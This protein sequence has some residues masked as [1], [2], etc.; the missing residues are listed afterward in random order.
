M[1]NLNLKEK[2]MKSKTT[3]PALASGAEKTG[4]TKKSLNEYYNKTHD[5][6]ILKSM[7]HNLEYP[8]IINLLA[9][10]IARR[11]ERGSV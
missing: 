2:I 4:T 9:G 7:A 1:L 11:L 8:P 5:I 10:S 6:A 3:N